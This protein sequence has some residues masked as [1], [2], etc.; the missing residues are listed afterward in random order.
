MK[1]QQLYIKKYTIFNSITNDFESHEI[2]NIAENY[3]NN[4]ILILDTSYKIL[5]LSKLATLLH[6]SINNHN[7]NY[8][9]VSKIIENIK[10]D[11][12]MNTVYNST[13]AFFHFTNE[14]L[15]FCGIK[16]NEITTAYICVVKKYRDFDFDDLNLVNTLSKTLSIQI[17]KNN[18]FI[19]TSGLEEEYYLN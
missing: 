15:I 5:G 10:E 11:N 2:L 12:C 13:E 18:L 9:L 8:Y 14:K 3:L 16:T 19:S 1:K 6:D 7:E 4:P 17:Q